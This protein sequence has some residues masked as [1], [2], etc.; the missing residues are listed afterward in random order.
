MKYLR[1][2]NPEPSRKPPRTQFNGRHLLAVALGSMLA[3]AAAT[4]L[5]FWTLIHSGADS[6]TVFNVAVTVAI[7]GAALGTLLTLR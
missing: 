2:Y 7:T 6:D 3:G 4:G 5:I 1:T